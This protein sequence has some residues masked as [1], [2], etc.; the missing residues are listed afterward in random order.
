[1]DVDGP[2]G[3]DLTRIIEE[4]RAQYEKIA[5]KNQEELKAW[6]DSQ[7]SVHTHT[8]NS[9]AVFVEHCFVGLHVF[10]LVSRSQR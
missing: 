10:Y 2:K 3:Q 6:H 5:L 9:L 1:M 8:I 4:I 7:V